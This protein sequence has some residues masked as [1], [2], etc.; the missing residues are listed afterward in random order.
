M[1]ILKRATKLVFANDPVKP[2][3]K[4]KRKDRALKTLTE[5]ELIQLESQIGV[6]VF[7]PASANV[8]RREFFNLDKDTW[9]WHESAKQADG[10]LSEVT[11]RYEVQPKGI[12]KV[13]PGPRYDYLEGAELQNFVLAV[14]EY[15]ERVSREL[16]KRDPRTGQPLV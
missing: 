2:M 16:Y 9:I 11:V 12:L 1:G 15:Y 10:S 4:L 13:H 14:N 3:L 8:V 6:T 5:R 7:G